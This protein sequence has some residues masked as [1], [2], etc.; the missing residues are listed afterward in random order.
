MPGK[1]LELIKIKNVNHK[2]KSSS[3]AFLLCTFLGFLG[4]H[5]F[6]TGYYLIGIFQFLTCGGFIIWF[7]I[8]IVS[9]FRNDFRDSNDNPLIN[10]NSK[11]AS[12]LITLAVIF[13]FGWSVFYVQKVMEIKTKLVNIKE[14]KIT[15][16]TQPKTNS[17]QQKETVITKSG[18]K[19]V[20]D[21]MCQDLKG[22]LMICGVVKNTTNYP[23]KNIEIKIELFDGNKNFINF[24]RGK[25]YS[26]KANSKQEFMAPIYYQTVD[27]Y[28][29]VK[30][31]LR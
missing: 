30:V 16:Q 6:Y 29:I 9:L 8:D 27:S 12:G 28:R 7:L 17:T 24:T 11:L 4:M 2:E 22:N 26:L 21:N 23:A 13:A 1:N 3:V 5:R 19:V 20:K 15:P 10:H 31:E 18:I 14:E 25:I